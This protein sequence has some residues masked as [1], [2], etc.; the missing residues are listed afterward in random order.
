MWIHDVPYVYAVNIIKYGNQVK[1]L[2]SET[3]AI[4]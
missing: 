1:D 2:C 4:S 3:M